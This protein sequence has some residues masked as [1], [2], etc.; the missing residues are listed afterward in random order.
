MMFMTHHKVSRAVAAS[1][2]SDHWHSLHVHG[3]NY[4]YVQVFM[5][6]RL[7]EVNT[8]RKG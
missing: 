8:N 2:G 5:S 4:G 3:I 1:R 7:E 6:H